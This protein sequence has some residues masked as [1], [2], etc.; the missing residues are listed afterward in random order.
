MCMRHGVSQSSKWSKI[1]APVSTMACQLRPTCSW[2]FPSSVG[3]PSRWSRTL[4]PV[5]TSLGSSDCRSVDASTRGRGR[6]RKQPG[7]PPRVQPGRLTVYKRLTGSTCTCDHTTK[8]LHRSVALLKQKEDSIFARAY[9]CRSS[10]RSR[11]RV[12]ATP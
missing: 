3:R 10:K 7:D 4:L 5:L 8:G 12:D 6:P 2:W 1:R 9:R 11:N